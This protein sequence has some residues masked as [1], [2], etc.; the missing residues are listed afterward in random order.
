MNKVAIITDSIALAPSEIVEKYGIW[1][2][3]LPIIIDGESYPETELDLPQ[4]YSRLKSADHL[5]TTSSP[6]VGDYLK[7][8][9][10]V[11]EK[12]ESILCITLTSGFSTAYEVAI[13]AK[14]MVE[15]ELPQMVIEVIDSRTVCGAQLLVVLEAAR[16]AARGGTLPEV[17]EVANNIASRVS[18][19]HLFNDLHYLERGGRIGK[20]RAWASSKV[21]TRALLE[22][23]ASTGGVMQPLARTRTKTKAVEKLLEVV[24]E[25]SGG[26]KLH[27]VVNHTHVPHE[28]EELKNQL[29]SEFQCAELYVTEALPVVATQNGPGC[30]YLSWYGED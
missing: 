3:P 22:V 23:D 4:F 20:A 14:K 29:L 9:R 5:P 15:E 2:V 28:A 16:T 7:A 8:F 11:S 10:E 30:V 26:K 12:S 18:Q 1:L 6:S 27:A 21:P 19:F 24:R 17:A 13:Q 25:R